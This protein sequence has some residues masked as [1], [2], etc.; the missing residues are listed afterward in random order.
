MTDTR[1]RHLSLASVIAAGVAALVA[2]QFLAPSAFGTQPNGAAGA[3]R[4]V[5]KPPIVLVHGAFA[6]AGSWNR[7]IPTL[8]DDG[9][10]VIAG[11]SPLTSL[12]DDIATTTRVIDAQVGPVVAVGHSYGGVVI[13]GAAAGSAKVKSLVYVAAFAPGT[14]EAVSARGRSSRLRHSPPRSY[15]TRQA[16]STSTARSS[17]TRSARTFRWR[18]RA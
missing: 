8:L 1:Y 18:T 12:A 14:G 11:Q 15:P 10:G 17:T 2:L 3:A 7:V 6:D 5:A 16:F 9:Y 4:R 13:T